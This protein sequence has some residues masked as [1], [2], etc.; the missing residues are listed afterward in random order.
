M[1]GS[2]RGVGGSGRICAPR[3]DGRL[4][5]QNSR[6]RGSA[7]QNPLVLVPADHLGPV[8]FLVPGVRVSLRA[9]KPEFRCEQGDPLPAQLR[10]QRRRLNL[11]V[12][13]AAAVVGIRRWTFGLWENGQ[14]RPQARYREAITRFLGRE[15]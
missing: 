1:G 14:Q 2:L 7:C 12:E 4:E 15:P 8:A 11:S 13:E 9:S 5:V 3:S 10:G 6:P